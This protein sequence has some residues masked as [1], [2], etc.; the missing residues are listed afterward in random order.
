V[1][2]LL[3]QDPRT[4]GSYTTLGRLGHG[5]MGV[6][7][8]GQSR[9]GRRVAIKTIHHH[10]AADPHYRLRFAREVQAA[11]RVSGAF[12]ASVEDSGTD[13]ELLWLA[14]VYI[15]GAS[16]EQAMRRDVMWP[17]VRVRELGAKL[18]EALEAIHRE[19]IVHRDL[20][21]SNILLS[22]EGPK[23]IDFGISAL[24]DATALTR[25]DARPGTTLYM[26]PEHFTGEPL[27]PATDVFALG[28]VLYFAATGLPPFGLE[29]TEAVLI[30]R[31]LHEPPTMNGIPRAL[32][33]ILSDCLAKDKRNRPSPTAL[34]SRLLPASEAAP[35]FIPQRSRHRPVPAPA[36]PS[37]RQ[38]SQLVATGHMD[39][40]I[41]L[42]NLAT[43]QL[44][45]TLTGHTR[46]VNTVAFSP[47][48]SLLASG[49]HDC[50]VRVWNPVTGQ[51]VRTLTGHTD[52]V[53]S[54]SFSAD[55]TL[56]ATS[57]QTGPVRLWDP[58]TGEQLR[59]LTGDPGWIKSIA[60]SP[61]CSLLAVAADETWLWDPATGQHLRT[62]PGNREW[63]KAVAFNHDGAILA[64]GADEGTV[65]LWDPE[66]SQHLGTVAG[67]GGQIY[68]LAF[69][70]DRTMLAIGCTDGTV[71][72]WEP[73]SVTELRA[74]T[75]RVWALAFGDSTLLASGSADGTSLLWDTATGQYLR[76]LTDTGVP[77][78]AVAFPR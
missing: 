21:P 69:A 50:T 65:T 29:E 13:G 42:W 58:G 48:G 19:G 30:N 27:D 17:E 1:D 47:D 35:T 38:G 70:P 5:G 59:T 43:A 57:G 12:T 9:A 62:L 16:L 32:S 8:L 39:G 71:R 52:W 18:A 37:A 67:D 64:V 3:P 4:I 15:Q 73:G 36:P 54:L 11:G 66:T 28:G 77:V 61:D 34:V 33:W 75:D 22:P 78:S 51:P 14:T 44:V 49:S 41:L 76:T 53:W 25:T 6:V 26:A 74:H 68:A 7:F 63:A 20:K 40:S 31:I 55:G 46:G 2:P 45:R 10:Y 60:F 23:V 56:L 72:L 24:A